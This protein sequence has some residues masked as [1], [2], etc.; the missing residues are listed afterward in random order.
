MAYEVNKTDEQWRAELSPEQYAVLRQAG[1]EAPA[2]LAKAA[3]CSKFTT[4]TMP[5]TI[6][7]SM[8]A[9]RTRST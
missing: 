3:D 1:T 4:G 8:P 6:G 2:F 5:G 7:T 9:A